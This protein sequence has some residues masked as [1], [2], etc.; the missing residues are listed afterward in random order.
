MADSNSESQSHA[1]AP[2]YTAVIATCER[3]Q[4]LEQT[5]ESLAIQSHRPKRV[6]IVDASPDQK[7]E[8]VVE[9]Y[10]EKLQVTYEKARQC[11]AARQ[12]NQGAEKVETPL[13]AF[14]DDDVRIPANSLEEICRVF[15]KD[16]ENRIGG[17]AARIVGMQHST[18]R[19][20]LRLYYRLQAGFSHPT[21]GGKLFGP[22]I[23]CLPTY[24]ES[25]DTLIPADWL[26]STCVFYRTELFQRE[27]FPEFEGYSFLED[28]H[29]SSRI[30]WTHQL[31]FH[32]SAMFEHLDAPSRFK[33][34]VRGLA[35]MRVHHQRQVARD[36]LG[37]GGL[38]LSWKLALHRLFATVSIL[39]GRS[40]AWREEL[41]GTW[42]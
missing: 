23:N 16:S 21:Y 33:R 22:G 9:R 27:K 4:E 37:L 29:L 5:L 12:R 25:S 38:E 35:R 24:T 17:V 26:N 42:T 2:D 39:R 41:I 18:P 13:V 15:G 32:S 40:G 6:I 14:I 7:T 19:G 34:D 20:L 3:P 31:F 30:G 1:P 36:I 28:V 10:R 8:A 11:S